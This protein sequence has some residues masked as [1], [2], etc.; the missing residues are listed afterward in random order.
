MSLL[1][2]LF[3][4]GALAVALP[5]EGGRPGAVLVLSDITR[6]KRLERV[7]TDFVANVSHELRTPITLIKGFA[8]TLEADPSEAGRFIGI[9]KRHADRMAAIVEDLLT[10]ASLEGPE[11]GRLETTETEAGTLIARA[12]ESLGD[13]RP[14]DGLRGGADTPWRDYRRGAPRR[15]GRNNFV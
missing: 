13:A 9:I 14:R 7:R 15:D 2:P 4:L 5:L 10:L 1:S 12:I 3:L 6:L 8:E 11:R